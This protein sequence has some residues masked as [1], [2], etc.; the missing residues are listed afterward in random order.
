MKL[1]LRHFIVYILILISLSFGCLAID[2]FAFTERLYDGKS[3]TEYAEISD[4]P[5]ISGHSAYVYNIDTSSVIYQK[6]QNDIVYP[7]STVKLMTAIVAYENISDL[8]TKITASTTAINATKG[9]NMAVKVGEEFTVEQLLN[10]LL[11]TGAND[12]ANMLAEYVAGDII[13]FCDLMNQKAKELGAV[14]TYFTN[15]TGLH[16]PEMV[17]TA[18]DIAIIASYF[19]SKDVLFNMSNTTRYTIDPTPFTKQQRILLN[20]NLLISRMRS[21]E[22]YYSKAD[23]MSLGNTPEAGDCIVTSATDENGMTYICVVM[24]AYS[25]DDKNLACI[26]ATKLLKFTLESFSYVGVLSDKTIICEIPVDLAVDTDYI[27]L[28]PDTSL[29]ALLPSNFDYKTHISIEPRVSYTSA[30]APIKEGDVYGE[31]VVKYK[32]DIIL[33]TVKLVSSRNVEKSNVLHLLNTLENI[34]FG[35]WFRVFGISA[36]VLFILYFT[37]SIIMPSRRYNKRRR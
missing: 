15:P 6:N 5:T 23:G 26:D 24:N 37:A 13:S 18:R 9:S 21:E 33:G 3:L 30:T 14:N 7:A 22:Y 35:R 25:T 10:G 31:A 27:T 32:N 2:D 20:R 29:N 4:F 1:N 36:L 19:Y 12:A 34:I 28:M 17:T 8:S 16:S 11:I